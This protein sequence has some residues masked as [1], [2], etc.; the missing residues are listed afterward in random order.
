VVSLGSRSCSR[1][2]SMKESGGRPREMK[3]DSG[4]S[5][6]SAPELEAALLAKV[7]GASAGYKRQSQLQS[8]QSKEQTPA[9]SGGSSGG[10]TSVQ[11]SASFPKHRRAGILQQQTSASGS[12]AGRT[13]FAGGTLSGRSKTITFVSP[14][15]TASESEEQEKLFVPERRRRQPDSDATAYEPEDSSGDD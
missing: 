11:R 3:E 6:I 2:Q 4:V 7:P 12:T 5:G 13:A 10:T 1:R 15:S 8:Q 14:I 9:G